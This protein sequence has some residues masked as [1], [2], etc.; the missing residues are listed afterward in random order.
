MR[1]DVGLSPWASLLFIY[2]HHSGVCHRPCREG[3]R[4]RERERESMPVAV[5]LL[6]T[7]PCAFYNGIY[8]VG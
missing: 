6:A 7:G 4:G 3:E 2:I 8:P 1:N 5:V